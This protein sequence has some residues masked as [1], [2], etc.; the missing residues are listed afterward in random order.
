MSTVGV[1]KG[2]NFISGIVLKRLN[3]ISEIEQKALLVKHRRRHYG[4]NQNIK[5][6]E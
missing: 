4:Y 2:L 6:W 3:F 1:L 5:I